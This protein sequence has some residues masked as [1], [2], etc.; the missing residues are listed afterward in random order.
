MED[1]GWPRETGVIQLNHP[2]GGLQF[3]RDFAWP[4][5]IGLDLTAPLPATYDGSGQSLFL[6]TPQGAR[7]SNAD[8]HAQEVMNGTS[9]AQFLQYRAVWHYLLDQG[10]VR[11]GTANS[12]S[13]TLTDNVLGT[14]RTVVWT[15]QRVGPGFDP[16][17]FNA[18]VRA[19]HMIGTN[20]PVI[21]L[22]T[23]DAD[24][25]TRTP[26]VEPFAPN[27]GGAVR[28]VVRAAPWVP[29]E[30]VRVVVN[31][32][33]VRT[34]VP[35]VVAPADPFGTEGL[36]R[37]DVSVPFAELLPASGD[38]WIVVEAGGPLVEN[39]DLDCDG[40]PDTG[41]NDGDGKID[42]RDVEELTED[43]GADC[44]D[45][46]GPLTEP[47][48]PERDTPRFWFDRVTPG[49]SPTAFTNPLI[50]DRDGG[51]FAGVRR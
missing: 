22:S 41:D 6:R 8:Y 20:G 2:W 18:D 34:L 11:A 9:N 7:F 42:W 37:L 21:E 35:D 40:V 15:D 14:P 17:A 33:V 28:I 1:A 39:A 32:E 30:E 4:T 25:G 48:P 12:D 19:G 10:V 46:V 38:A 36:E 44:F 16:A 26:S 5:A 23:V 47:A 51:G 13:H 29:V 50:L 45:T 31:G 3:G 24:G 49:G 27:E 43:P